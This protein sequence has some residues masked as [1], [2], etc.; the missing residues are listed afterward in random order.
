MERIEEEEKK[1]K[2]KLK[3]KGLIAWLGLD[4]IANDLKVVYNNIIYAYFCKDK[5]IRLII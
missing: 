5:P 3:K 2:E 1:R 4:S